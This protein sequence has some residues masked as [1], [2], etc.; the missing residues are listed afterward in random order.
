MTPVHELKAHDTMNNLELWLT[1]M[2][3]GSRFY[4][5][6]MDVDDLSLGFRCYEELYVV[7]NM[8]DSGWWSQGSKCYE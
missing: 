4:K 3:Q 7:V 1:W 2:T 6:L 8:N 5:Q